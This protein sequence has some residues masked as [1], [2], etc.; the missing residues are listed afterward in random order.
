MAGFDEDAEGGAA[1][2][3]E[4]EGIDGQQA[5][6]LA[7]A[8]ESA[9]EVERN[10]ASKV[11]RIAIEAAVREAEARAEARQAEAVRQ[12]V[13]AAEVQFGVAAADERE[14]AIRAACNKV[15]E[16][17]ANSR[18]LEVAGITAEMA[19]RAEADKL[20]AVQEAL[21]TAVPDAVARVLATRSAQEES[22]MERARSVAEAARVEAV[23]HAV[24]AERQ[25]AAAAHASAVAEAVVEAESCARTLA[26]GEAADALKR[27]REKHVKELEDL[28]T[29][30]AVA[31]D[32]KIS[33]V[34]AA[35]AAEREAWQ[36]EKHRAVQAAVRATLATR[37][38]CEAAA[39]SAQPSVGAAHAPTP[40]LSRTQVAEP[41]GKEAR[42]PRGKPTSPRQDQPPSPRDRKQAQAKGEKATAQ[43]SPTHQRQLSWDDDRTAPIPIVPPHPPASVTAP[44]LSTAAGVQRKPTP[45]ALDLANAALATAS[46]LPLPPPPPPPPPLPTTGFQFSRPDRAVS[47]TSLNR[48]AEKSIDAA[49]QGGSDSDDP[50]DGHSSAAE[51]TDDELVMQAQKPQRARPTGPG[52]P[53]RRPPESPPEEVSVL[54]SLWKSIGL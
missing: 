27:M 41:R 50:E 24:Q 18:R 53:R 32:T 20:V 51:S 9:L 52:R 8:V 3:A 12:A 31:L 11:Q 10:Q 34:T 43:N 5:E 25:Q 21:A 37:A 45:A 13:A 4:P 19:A 26:M 36:E 42:S 6:L 29:Q 16:E 54:S 1:H 48:D 30:H 49:G 22:A 28:A 47:A 7:S 33:E 44:L 23:E 14:A 17:E 2:G 15:R 35:F 39:P 46:S 40:T 38:P